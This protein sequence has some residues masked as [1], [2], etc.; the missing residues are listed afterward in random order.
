MAKNRPL[1]DLLKRRWPLLG[2]GA[3]VIAD[4]AEKSVQD[5][6][7]DPDASGVTHVDSAAIAHVAETMAPIVANAQNAEPKRRSRVVSGGTAAAGGGFMVMLG[8]VVETWLESGGAPAW[9]LPTYY[10]LFGGA[11]AGGGLFALYGRLKKALP[12][13][14][15]HWWNPLSWPA[16]GAE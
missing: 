8:P 9:V 1:V 7:D 10:F 12:P 2:A 13:M 4:L 3:E 6:A 14:K 11:A 16:L 15:F 5:A